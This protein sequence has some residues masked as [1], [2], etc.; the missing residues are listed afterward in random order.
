MHT[1]QFVKSFCNMV[2]SEFMLLLNILG[3]LSFPF[4]GI[5]H[6]YSLV[7]SLLEEGASPNLILP[8]EG[9]SPFHLAVG[10]ESRRALAL[11][12]LFLE[13]DGNPNVR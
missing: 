5:L 4:P 3:H 9:I 10:S 8:A 2:S 7:S 6:S 11:I 13:H 12:A 1:I